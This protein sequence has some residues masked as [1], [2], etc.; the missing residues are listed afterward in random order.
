MPLDVEQMDLAQL[1]F[2][3]I[4]TL[5]AYRREVQKLDAPDA[6]MVIDR[7]EFV[8]KLLAFE[9]RMFLIKLRLKTEEAREV[10]NQG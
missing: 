8:R 10:S 7:A 3:F 4:T 5:R 2:A 6:L 9:D 1:R